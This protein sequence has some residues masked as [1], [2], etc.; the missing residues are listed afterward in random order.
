[1]SAAL[2]INDIHLTL[3]DEVLK[4]LDKAV[5]ETFS[6]FMG[7][8]PILKSSEKVESV[9]FD[10]YEISAIIA[11]IQKDI[12]GTLA[13]RFRQ[14][15]ILKLLSRIYGAELESVDNRIIGGVAELIN[16]IHGIAKEDLNLQGFHFQMCLPVVVIGQNH[17][18]VSSLS[19]SKMIMRYDL[20]GEEA[21]VELIVHKR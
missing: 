20:D 10:S 6:S 17:S 16:V 9:P 8:S 11:F 12:E 15:S 13:I 2:K 3:D 19:G 4:I 1:M 14:S 5:F 21:I 7:F 18:L